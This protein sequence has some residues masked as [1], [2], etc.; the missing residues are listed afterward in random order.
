MSV[1]PQA[2]KSAGHCVISTSALPRPRPRPS[3]FHRPRPPALSCPATP[4]TG[5]RPWPCDATI[6]P[7]R[8]AYHSPVRACTDT[9]TDTGTSATTCIGT[10]GPTCRCRSL[11][12]PHIP[13]VVQGHAG[14]YFQT[15]CS[16]SLLHGLVGLRITASLAIA[17]H[18]E[19]TAILRRSAPPS[20]LEHCQ[21]RPD[22]ASATSLCA[23]LTIV[24]YL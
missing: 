5:R 7:Q 18:P 11:P 17:I 15:L 2:H 16:I 12:C 22:S 13:S 14:K 20:S 1:A 21:A 3:S 24:V 10:K 8:T 9:C 23:V 4:S 19:R 6:Y